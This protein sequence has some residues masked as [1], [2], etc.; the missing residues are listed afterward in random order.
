MFYPYNSYRCLPNIPVLRKINNLLSVLRIRGRSTSLL[1]LV[2]PDQSSSFCANVQSLLSP[3]LLHLSA[4][5]PTHYSYLFFFLLIFL[6]V[7]LVFSHFV[8]CNKRE[9]KQT[10]SCSHPILFVGHSSFSLRS[11]NIRRYVFD[12]VSLYYLFSLSHK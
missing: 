9:N 1:F 12:R 6:F 2:L 7:L 3:F 8:C 10:Q 4:T 5:R 11:V